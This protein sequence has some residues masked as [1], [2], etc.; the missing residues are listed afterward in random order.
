[1][2]QTQILLTLSEIE[3][4]SL[5]NIWVTKCTL[6]TGTVVRNY[7]VQIRP[8]LAF[9]LPLIAMQTKEPEMLQPDSFCEH[10]MQQNATAAEAPIRTPMG[11]FI[12]LPKPLNSFRF[13]SGR[14]MQESGR[15]RREK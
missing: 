13:A 1:M 9:I 6:W 2:A 5:T 11:E 14:G 15:E 8:G 4:V 12:A 10:I 7:V 3:F